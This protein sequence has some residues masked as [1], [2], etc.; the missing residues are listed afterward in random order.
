M[1]LSSCVISL[2]HTGAA[3]A[4]VTAI[5]DDSSLVADSWLPAA[6]QTDTIIDVLSSSAEYSELLHHLQ[7]TGLVPEINQMRRATMFAPVNS[8]FHGTAED[9]ITRELLL[10]HLANQTIA[11]IDISSDTVVLTHAVPTSVVVNDTPVGVPILLSREDDNEESGR[12]LVNRVAQVVECDMYAGYNRGVVQAI[13][14]LLPVPKSLCRTL[15]DLPSTSMFSRLLG[16]D[17]D[18]SK[19]MIPTLS[20]FLIPTNKAFEI[21]NEVET[22]YLQSP[23]AIDDRA[24]LFWRHFIMDMIVPQELSSEKPLQVTASDGT[25]LSISSNFT[26]NGTFHSSETNILCDNGLVQTYDAIIDSDKQ[27][28]VFNP[29]KY[30]YGLQA[31]LFV[32]EL[33]VA[34]LS[35]LID[36]TTT[37]PQTI[38]LSEYVERPWDD[39]ATV[40]SRELSPRQDLSSGS[41]RY[42]YHFMEEQIAIDALAPNTT[43]LATSRMRSHKLGKYHQRAK[44]EISENEAIVNGHK[45][46]SGEY[47]IGNTSIYMLDGELDTPP[48]FSTA[49]GPFFQSSYSLKFLR[50]TG[51]LK[52]SNNGQGWTYLLPSRQA[53]D[54]ESLTRRYLQSNI[55]ALRAVLESMVFAT[56]FYSDDTARNVTLLSG[57]EAEISTVNTQTEE[58]IQTTFTLDGKQY[59]VD[60][61]DILFENGVA[62]SVHQVSL[63]A[64]VQISSEELIHVG[65]RSE[66]VDLLCKRGLGNVLRTNESYIILV[67]NMRSME[68]D[69]YN[70]SHKHIDLLLDIHLMPGN[71][72]GKLLSGEPIATLADGVS[73][74][75]RT[76]SDDLHF[77]KIENGQEYEVYVV[78][79]GSTTQFGTNQE[80]STILFLDGYISPEWISNPILQPPRGLRT[81]IAMLLGAAAGILLVFIVITF[82]LYA[83]VRSPK[84]DDSE[85]TGDGGDQQRR[86]LL[87][88]NSASSNRRRRAASGDYGTIESPAESRPSNPIQT[89]AVHEQREFGRHLDL[90]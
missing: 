48:S 37:D 64:T 19:E 7:R 6:G 14:T 21:Y 30:L 65:G 72:I 54:R 82:G 24:K 23:R 78:A 36:G 59:D 10:Y 2:I 5:S 66:F 62:H 76:V 73:L 70:L 61:S 86:P 27:L 74:V 40:S 57:L 32:E 20:T 49:L 22:K 69:G 12:W 1:L 42:S 52:P 25:S 75:A 51:L 8:A 58:G 31:D 60:A 47:K 18:C 55:T 38:F 41:A 44:I 79:R 71:P 9:E 35:H 16:L 67:P 34:G 26:I 13:D 53:W 84:L 28:V 50:A 46:I 15:Q 11:S 80:K 77:I 17:F 56:P 33:V 43:L 89:V 39:L 45:I 83:M 68:R 63:P 85:G 3:V 81:H 88:G 29:M 87:R 90:P 4:G